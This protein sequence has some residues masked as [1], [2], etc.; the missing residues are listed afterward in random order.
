MTTA[1][2]FTSD[3]STAVGAVNERQSRERWF[4]GVSS[5]TDTF[6]QKVNLNMQLENFRA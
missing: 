4:G 5:V 2:K 1:D 3:D 6:S